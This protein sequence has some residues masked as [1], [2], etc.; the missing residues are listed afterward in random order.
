MTYKRSTAR[1]CFE[2]NITILIGDVKNLNKNKKLRTNIRQCV[3]R[4]AI[5]QAS[6]A[7]E[8]Y[9]YD[10]CSNWVKN[11]IAH[12]ATV[13]QL[14]RNLVA[15]AVGKNHLS[16]FENFLI[17]GDEGRF[18]SAIKN[19]GKLESFFNRAKPVDGLIYHAEFVSDR[20]YPS[21][22]NILALFRRFGI[23]DVFSEMGAKGRKDYK[24]IL[25]SF[26]DVRTQIA[27]EFTG[28]NFSNTDVLGHLDKIKG[29]VNC[30]DR[31]FYFHVKKTSGNM[32]W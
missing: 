20:K 14:P 4:N 15:W 24:S 22:K 16:I 31:V 17:K 13:S 3:L 30:L 32:Y 5:F 6:A 25:K 2:E 28:G 1:N 11:L 10:L 26:S 19:S 29:F 21:E 7:L 18:I 27:H 23:E 8:D 9:L 12:G